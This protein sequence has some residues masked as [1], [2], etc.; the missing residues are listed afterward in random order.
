MKQLA[1]TPQMGI[2][3]SV[4]VKPEHHIRESTNK[5][6]LSITSTPSLSLCLSFSLSFPPSSSDTREH[7]QEQSTHINPH[8]CTHTQTR[9]HTPITRNPY[10]SNR[11]YA[12]SHANALT[13]SLNNSSHTRIW[14][15][16]AH[17]HAYM[18]LSVFPYWYELMCMYTRVSV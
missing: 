2:C 12:S 9:A 1:A 8:I 4:N 15:V 5:S 6:D 17:K 13:H 11:A 10:C 18:R 14:R 3:K 16:H 7:P